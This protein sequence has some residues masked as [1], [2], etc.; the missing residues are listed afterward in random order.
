MRALSG[1]LVHPVLVVVSCLPLASTETADGLTARE[2]AAAFYA[3]R[4]RVERPQAGWQEVPAGLEDLRAESCGECHPDIYEEWR[5]STHALAWVDRQLQGEMAKSGNRWLC[6]NCHTP[7]MNQ[8]EAWA[9]GLVDGDVEQPLYVANPSFESSFR[10]EGITCASCHVRD[11]AVE[12]PT[13]IATEAH[14]TRLAGRFNDE[15]ICL[16]C[17]QAVQSYAGKDF[18]C[19]FE[20]GREWRESPYGQA[21]QSCQSCHMQPVTRPQAVGAEPRTGRRHYWPGAG[22]YKLEGVG[23]PLDQLGPGL[24]VEVEARESELV[25]TLSNSAAG[26]L[27]PT[28]DPERFVLVEV[29]LLDANGARVGEPHRERIGQLWE[30]YPEPKKLADNRLAPFEEREVRLRRPENAV[31][32]SLVATNHRISEEALAY[33]HLEGYPASR[34]THE[35][36]GRFPPAAASR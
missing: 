36:R 9:V 6:N 3:S 33:H 27:L 16:E 23:P 11:G 17:H 30:W 2:R 18:I 12:G 21:N 1:A 34:V 28:G 15:R 31:S 35:R 29:E 5:V 4:P 22:I 20:T 14:A 8:M 13:G 19:V 32:W 26:H 25:V 7:L 24:G 10:D